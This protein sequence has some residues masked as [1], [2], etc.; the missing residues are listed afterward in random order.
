MTTEASAPRSRRTPPATPPAARRLDLGRRLRVLA[1]VDEGILDQ[2]PLER[3]R[4]VG[5]GGV[6][7]GTAVVAG[8]SMWFALSQ[9]LGGA[10][11]AMLV[12]TVIWALIV[13]NLDRWLVSTVTGMWQRRL[14]M[15]IPRLLVAVVLGF[16]IAEP[17]VLR[18]FETA[19]V[20]HVVDERQEA[21]NAERDLLVACNPKTPST[22][23]PPQ[24]CRNALLLASTPAA[25]EARLAQLKEDARRL[26]AQ[27]DAGSRRHA[28]L[29]DQAT[30][31]CAGRDG[32]GLSG[33][34]GWGPRC[35]R[36]QQEADDYAVRNRLSANAAE[37][38]ALNTQISEL[39][40]SLATTRNEYGKRVEDAVEARV[41]A[42]P[43]P[44]DPVGLLERM[45]ALDEVT[46]ENT[47][48]F[49]ASWL[50]RL[51]LILIDCLPVLVK[52]MGGTS[53]YDRMV[54]HENRVRERIHDKTLHYSAE[55]RLGELELQAYRDSED[56]RRRRQRID[57][58]GKAADAGMRAEVEEM[59]RKRAEELSRRGDR[60]ERRNGAHV[61]TG[62][63]RPFSG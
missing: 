61:G 29:I 17:L 63:T 24:D 12:P 38:Q 20:Q 49:G 55:R 4:Y 51:F 19:I 26:K 18:V 47:Y 45:R 33:R 58:E 7:L 5:L 48:L 34:A 8:I 21:R 23:P 13:L 15:L 57:V 53:T 30:D 36:L 50:F 28:E 60:T 46:A 59:V 40:G 43:G 27:V 14:L 62:L 35:R 22:A 2:V 10:H 37:L 11:I 44:E 25:D 56:L 52:L 41:A 39:S 3:T 54:E 16:I 9:V 6:I 32:A 1:G 31:E 42:L